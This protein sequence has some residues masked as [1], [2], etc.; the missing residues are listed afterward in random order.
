VF[1]D[2]QTPWESLACVDPRSDGNMLG[3]QDIRKESKPEAC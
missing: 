2:G 1:R 3:S